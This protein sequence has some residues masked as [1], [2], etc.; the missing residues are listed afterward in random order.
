MEFVLNVAGRYNAQT[1]NITNYAGGRRRGGDVVG[2]PPWLAG[3]A[4][5]KE[6]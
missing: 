2:Q 3:R 5:Q 6:E 4:L 1:I